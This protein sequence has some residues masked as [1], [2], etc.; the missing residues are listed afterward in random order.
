MGLSWAGHGSYST[1]G[2]FIAPLEFPR[3]MP[4][5]RAYLPYKRP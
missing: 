4:L 3:Q 1:S 2:G 5:D